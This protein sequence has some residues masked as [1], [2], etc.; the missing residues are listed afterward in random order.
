MNLK[1]VF[2]DED[3][4]QF[5][6]VIE[7]IGKGASAK[8]FKVRR[9]ADQKVCVLKYMKPYDEFEKQLIIDE[10]GILKFNPGDSII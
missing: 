5:F 1:N 7:P 9:I 2:R 4:S 6:E 10:V 3:P 8:I